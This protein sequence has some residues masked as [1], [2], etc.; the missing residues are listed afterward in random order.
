M[1]TR[2][3]LLVAGMLAHLGLLCSQP[4]EPVSCRRMVVRDASSGREIVLGDVDGSGRVGIHFVGTSCRVRVS[5]GLG[6][7][8]PRIEIENP[9]G[10]VHAGFVEDGDPL[11]LCLRVRAGHLTSTG[12][13]ID[14]DAAFILNSM[15]RLEGQLRGMWALCSDE[16]AMI[17]G[18]VNDWQQAWLACDEEGIAVKATRDDVGWEF[19]CDAKWAAYVGTPH[20]FSGRAWPHDESESDPAATGK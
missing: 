3:G 16:Q 2:S 8:L 11:A 13:A 12:L 6:R 14:D 5:L 15:A 19:L 1:V 17:R 4:A 9:A 7:E 10:A 18:A 20:F